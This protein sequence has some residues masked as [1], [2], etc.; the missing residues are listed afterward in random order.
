MCLN[1]SI[2]T[3]GGYHLELIDYD[4]HDAIPYEIFEGYT[5]E[6]A[7]APGYF[8]SELGIVYGPGKIGNRGY[9]RLSSYTNDAY[10][11]Q[12]VDLHINGKRRH[13]YVAVLVAEAFIPNPHEY[14]QVRHKD[15]NPYNNRVSNLEW[16]TNLDN[17]HDAIRHGTF[18]YPTQEL[19]ER[20]NQARRTPVKAINVE[21]G[22]EYIFPSQVDAANELGLR[23]SGINLTLSGRY[24]QTGGYEFEYLDK[25]EFES[26]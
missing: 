11:H 25:E 7:Y 9:H 4:Y 18:P 23:R 5:V 3:C 8:V 14:P 19:I 15:G 22:K 24:K 10:G 13:K 16:G 2:P 17:V 21:S 12:V 26:K 20:A 6:I 1:G